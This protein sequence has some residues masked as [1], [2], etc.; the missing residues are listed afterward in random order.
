MG[1]TNSGI[2]MGS[3]NLSVPIKRVFMMGN[4]PSGMRMVSQWSKGLS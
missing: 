3:K 1:S 2:K 4:G